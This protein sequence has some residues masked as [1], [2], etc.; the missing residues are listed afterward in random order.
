MLRKAHSRSQIIF[1]NF[2]KNYM[3]DFWKTRKKLLTLISV[4]DGGGPSQQP[5]EELGE[6]ALLRGGPRPRAMQDGGQQII[7]KEQSHEISCLLFSSFEPARAI[8]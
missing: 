6:G 1:L 7:L 3:T 2:L 4:P 5:A 8:D